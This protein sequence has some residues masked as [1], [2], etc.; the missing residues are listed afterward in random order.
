MR[1]ET[2][3]LSVGVAVIFTLP[4]V[5]MGVS[6]CFLQLTIH[7]LLLTIPVSSYNSCKPTTVLY[8]V[9]IDYRLQKSTMLHDCCKYVDAKELYLSMR[10]AWRPTRQTVISV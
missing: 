9:M 8:S 1:A 5:C 3:C 10:A 4:A 7:D 2:T 6:W